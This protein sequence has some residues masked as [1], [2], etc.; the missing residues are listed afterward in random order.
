MTKTI[1]VRPTPRVKFDH[2]PS[3]TSAT[4]QRRRDKVDKRARDG[5]LDMC[6]CWWQTMW[7]MGKCPAPHLPT[8]TVRD[9]FLAVKA[10]E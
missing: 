2:D 7:F 6:L 9:P 4:T 1:A 5:N 8:G 3:W 10:V